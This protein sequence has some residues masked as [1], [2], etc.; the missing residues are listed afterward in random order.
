MY[1][2]YLTLRKHA[3]AP[4]R[5]MVSA[6]VQDRAMLIWLDGNYNRKGH[7]NENLAR[8]L[9]ELFTLGEGEYSEHDVREAARA[10]TGWTVRNGKVTFEPDQHDSDSKQI[11][12]NTGNFDADGLVQLVMNHPAVAHRVAWRICDHFFGRDQAPD[13]AV[14]SLAKILRESNLDIGSA[15][16]TVLRSSLFFDDSQRSARFSSPGSFVAAN[17]RSLE[18]HDG[19][20]PLVP[21]VAAYWM[22]DLG[23]DL[24]QPPGVGG[25]PGGTTWISSSTL[26]D[27]ARFALRLNNAT[28]HARGAGADLNEL[29]RRHRQPAS[30]FAGRLLFGEDRLVAGDLPQVLT[31]T[32]AQ[33]D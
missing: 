14:E 5:E 20:N 4:F 31:S 18:L 3:R 7:A 6:M 27:R 1:E 8:E 2:Q 15:I 17:I 9:M 12:G 22:R 10:L 23:Q 24:F 29:A 11:L 33:F 19:T 32:R 16:A 30:S 25:W 13:A 28:L 21:E 26:V